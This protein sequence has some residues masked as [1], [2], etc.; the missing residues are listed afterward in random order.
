M[1]P[2]NRIA[3]ALPVGAMQTYRIVAP[4][5]QLVRAACELVGCAAWRHGWQ[6]A[7]DESTELGRRQAHYIRYASG[8]THREQR[9]AAGL[10]VFRFEPHQRCFAD[11]RTR[12]ETYLV[13]GGDWRQRLG[14]IRRHVRPADWV[15]DFAEHQARLNRAIER[16]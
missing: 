7:V 10:T 8:R 9:T 2:I 12:P 15:E 1:R 5:D 4:P 16:G 6:T 11:H 13:Q 14:L 3:P